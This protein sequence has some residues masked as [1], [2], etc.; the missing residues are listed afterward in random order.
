MMF[1]KIALTLLCVVGITGL[2]A[3]ETQTPWETMDRATL[4][5]AYNNSLAVPESK[6]MFNA[7]VEQSKALRAQYPQHLDLVYGPRVR[8]RI[9][10]FS[11][12]ANTPVLVFIHGGFWQM[13]SKDDFAFLAAGFLKEGISVA[14]V[15]YPLGPDATM[16]EIVADSRLAIRYLAQ[17]LPEL[18]GDPRRVVI[19]GWSSGGH[20]ATMVL[21]DPLLRAGVSVSGL[22]ELKPLLKSYI[23]DKLHMDEVTAERNS[24]MR[25][26]PGLSKPL[27]LFVGTAEL[28][29]MRRQTRDYA[30]A[31]LAA[32]LPVAYAEI[33][34][35]NHYT[36]LNDMMSP[37]GKIH[38]EIVGLLHP[39]P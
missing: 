30:Q 36:I 37:E 39:G 34:G 11:A 28:P 17:H 21:D 15:G 1:K 33:P 10:Y 24:P 35:A 31:R 32:G 4:D 25:Q 26:L 20:L 38:R 6:S 8:D 3:A 14:M 29:E 19:S 2:Q 27:A 23:N 12:G 5:Q 18:G 13:R 22:F 9:D 16:D 7:W